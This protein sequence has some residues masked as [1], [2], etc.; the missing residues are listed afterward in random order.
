MFI[1]TTKTKFK[2]RCQLNC[3]TRKVQINN[4]IDIVVLLKRNFFPN[5][6]VALANTLWVVLSS[7]HLCVL[8][9]RCVLCHESFLHCFSLFE[10]LQNLHS[11]SCCD[12]VFPWQ[13][14]II[15]LISQTLFSVAK[16]KKN[17]I[18][19]DFQIIQISN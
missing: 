19:L 14:F 10:L 9:I 1:I 8:H 16:T 17:I 18:V 3:Q 6:T 2:M 15:Y 11:Q 13:R 5:V 7:G 4:V 12:S